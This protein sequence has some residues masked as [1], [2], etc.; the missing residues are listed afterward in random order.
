MW[1][2]FLDGSLLSLDS[3]C[4]SMDFGEGGARWD[5]VLVYSSHGAD[6]HHLRLVCR[7]HPKETR[8]L[9][10]K[11]VFLRRAWRDLV[12]SAPNVSQRFSSSK[13]TRRGTT[14]KNYPFLLFCSAVVMPTAYWILTIEIGIV[15]QND[16]I[17]SLTF[18]QVGI[19]G[20]LFY[21]SFD[22]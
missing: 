2:N 10:S 20:I 17:S 21:S 7:N 15:G 13:L 9:G 16:E 6:P 19:F 4:F 5:S 22:S 8:N 1:W 11:P 12:S 14:V 3:F 18:S